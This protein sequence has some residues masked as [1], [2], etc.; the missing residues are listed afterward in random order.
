MFR[1]PSMITRCFRE[2]R[3]GAGSVFVAFLIAAAHALP[4]T[5]QKTEPANHVEEDVE[6]WQE[7]RDQWKDQSLAEIE[8]DDSA[9]QDEAI[10][11]LTA[12]PPHEEAWDGFVRRQLRS[13]DL[14]AVGL[15]MELLFASSIEFDERV[16][17]VHAALATASDHIT[18]QTVKN[19]RTRARAFAS[20]RASN[21][22][23][24]ETMAA[25]Q[26]VEQA[27]RHFNG[28]SRLYEAV[29]KSMLADDQPTPT[30]FNLL[31]SRGTSDVETGRRLLEL[32]RNDE[33]KTAAIA[34]RVLNEV[35]RKAPTNDVASAPSD[36]K[37]H[38]YAQRIISRYDTNNS[39]DLTDNEWKSMLIDPSPADLNQDGKVTAHEYARWLQD[40]T[41]SP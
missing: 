6:Q 26:I 31:F 36:D 11:F 14:D 12:N 32:A 7:L 10:A 38:H 37:Y 34:S 17:L 4:A 9:I 22:I 19:Q 40:R 18:D 28:D 39:G 1:A 15:G 35:L 2:R 27:N 3:T 13:E 5:A 16:E 33:E 8:N 23:T 41:K 20:P 29:M 24:D 21:R 25:N 30:V